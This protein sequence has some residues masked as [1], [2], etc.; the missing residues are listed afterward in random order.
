[1]MHEQH[2]DRD[3]LTKRRSI[4]FTEILKIFS[5]S[6]P[7]DPYVHRDAA[8]EVLKALEWQGDANIDKFLSLWVECAKDVGE[9]EFEMKIE[10]RGEPWL[11]KRVMKSNKISRNNGDYDITEELII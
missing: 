9:Q 6:M 8:W 4:H 5:L 10:E 11:R 1:M 2:M 3:D 7:I